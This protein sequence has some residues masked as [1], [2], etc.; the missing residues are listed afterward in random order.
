LIATVCLFTYNIDQASTNPHVSR[1]YSVLEKFMLWTT[2]LIY[3]TPI[4]KS[5]SDAQMPDIEAFWYYWGY[6][7]PI[8]LGVSFVSKEIINYANGWEVLFDHDKMGKA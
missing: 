3:T 7:S 1:I 5:L 2:F 8:I 4:L 6:S